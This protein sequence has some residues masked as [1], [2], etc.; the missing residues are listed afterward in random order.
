MILRPYTQPPI[1]P[2]QVLVDELGFTNEQIEQYNA[3]S[4]IHLDQVR[5]NR[6]KIKD[7]K[8]K[9]F[10]SADK[11][12][13]AE[14]LNQVLNTIGNLE[15]ERDSLTY[16]HFKDIYGMCTDE[17]KKKFGSLI[18]MA[19][20]KGHP[21]EPSPNHEGGPPPHHPPHHPPKR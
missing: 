16:Y 15:K 21:N 1:H 14:E 10:N 20:D 11:E 7:A 3:L 18:N 12:L 17:Q 6:E 4:K 13:P 8:G 9:L 2:A 19:M 5:I